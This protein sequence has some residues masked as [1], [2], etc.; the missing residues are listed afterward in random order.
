[1]LNMG[2]APGQLEARMHNNALATGRQRT[3]Q[4]VGPPGSSN[5]GASGRTTGEEGI[6]CT[7]H[8]EHTNHKNNLPTHRTSN[9]RTLSARETH[10]IIELPCDTLPAV[11]CCTMARRRG[12]P[13][14]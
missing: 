5:S 4:M 3:K 1:M 10:V 13:V 6:P 9:L 8:G 11:Q 12:P 2:V 7:H 14:V